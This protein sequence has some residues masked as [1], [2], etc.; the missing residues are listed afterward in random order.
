MT[1][2]RWFD[3]DEV[4]SLVSISGAIA[5]IEAAL[6]GG[7]DPSADAARTAVPVAHGQLLLMPAQSLGGV[8]VKL[9]AV[10]PANPAHGLPRIQAVYVFMDPRTLAPVALLDGVALTSLRTPAMSAV[11]A[12]R[13][14]E[15]DA[16]R[17]VV[18]GVGPQ[19]QGHVE[20]MRAIRPIADVAV[21][22]R[23]AE[24]TARFAQHVG[25]RVGAIADVAH[26]D[27]VV[28]AT[29]AAEAL[30]DGELVRDRACV[31]AVGSHEPHVRELDEGLM[32]RAHVV[33]EDI[34]AALREAGD[35]I[36]A[37]LSATQLTPVAHLLDA[38]AVF[39][40]DRPR[41]FKSVGMAW[42]DL[43]VATEVVRRGGVAGDQAGSSSSG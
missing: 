39:D 4:N 43:V 33:V 14:A 42:Q 19:A 21:V 16:T 20:A 17:L 31:V 11:A 29:S 8:G 30:F 34:G 35:V 32:R 23:D 10:A 5:A 6:L 3:A 24:R 27:I 37:G 15:V 38:Q 40:D 2:P 1:A 41:V 26:A 7:L 36:R 9:A 12:R 18:F 22:G 28:C 13:L 25:G